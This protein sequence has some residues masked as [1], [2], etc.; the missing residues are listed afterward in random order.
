MALRIAVADAAVLGE[1]ADIAAR[2]FPLACPPSLTRNNIGAFIDEN[3]CAARFADYLTDP[4]RVVLAAAQNGRIIGYA[5]LIRGVVDDP[6]VQR[7]VATRPSAEL[8]KIYVLPE[9]HGAGASHALMDAALSHALDMGA[10]SVW[11]GVNQRN[12]RAQ[13]FY[14]KH[15][16]RVTG[17]KTFRVGAQ[18]ENDYVMVRQL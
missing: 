11:L 2:T 6:D 4:D 16:F 14:V 8:S 17:T 18:I 1:L 5:M 3:L 13:R 10:R 7:A 12:E 15:R 9:S